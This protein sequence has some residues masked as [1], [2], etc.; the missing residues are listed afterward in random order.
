M[1]RRLTWCVRPP[2]GTGTAFGIPFLYRIAGNVLES[3][4]Q[5]PA[6]WQAWQEQGTKGGI[7][8]E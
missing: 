2:L 6:L 1:L 3:G 4:K 7:H 5:V 8:G